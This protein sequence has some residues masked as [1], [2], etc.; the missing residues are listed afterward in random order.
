MTTAAVA[1]STTHQG[2]GIDWLILRVVLKNITALEIHLD[3]IST[4][5]NEQRSLVPI[6]V[7]ALPTIL[8]VINS[9]FLMG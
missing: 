3:V 6:W 8:L 4:N 2:V 9:D 7:S 5:P 1:T